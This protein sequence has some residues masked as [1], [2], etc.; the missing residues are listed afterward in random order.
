MCTDSFAGEQPS[1]SLATEFSDHATKWALCWSLLL[2]ASTTTLLQ[3]SETNRA[4]SWRTGRLR[5]RQRSRVTV[6]NKMSLAT[7]WAAVMAP[8]SNRRRSSG[9]CWLDCPSLLPKRRF[10]DNRPEIPTG[11]PRLSCKPA[12]PVLPCGW[13]TEGRRMW[14]INTHKKSE[15][16]GEIPVVSVHISKCDRQ[17]LSVSHLTDVTA[18]GGTGLKEL[19]PVGFCQLQDPVGCG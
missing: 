15:C 2:T 13:R 5:R 1:S 10:P 14:K 6:G 9:R 12:A 11:C 7:V 3:K 8:V 4:P 19:H 17:F 16:S 18:G